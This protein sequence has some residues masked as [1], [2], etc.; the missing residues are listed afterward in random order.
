M[1]LATHGILSTTSDLYLPWSNDVYSFDYD[2][3]SDYINVG[4]DPFLNFE[5]TD[6][7][8]LSCWFKCGSSSSTQT[9]LSK[10]NSSKLGYYLIMASNGRLFFSLKDSNGDRFTAFPNVAFNNN[11]W[12][13]VI[14]S[15]DGSSQIS[16]IKMYI[17]STQY[18]LNTSGTTL[19]GS[20]LTN[21]PFQIGARYNTDTMNGLIDEPS[22]FAR[23]LGSLNAS[24]IYGTGSAS[25]ITHLSSVGWWRAENATFNGSNWTVANA[26]KKGFN[27]TSVSMTSG[28]RVTDIPT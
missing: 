25:D 23:S 10:T 8:S 15:Y 2:G 22:I 5:R 6:S 16:G 24:D 17:D 13:N 12:H 14:V 28:S 27:G 21:E 18:L 3:V 19:T 26:Y 20:T 7:F 4:N 9:L 1:F 11:N